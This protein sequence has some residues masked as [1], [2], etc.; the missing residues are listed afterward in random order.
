ML[1]AQQ[2]AVLP[3]F[4][5]LF[6]GARILCR[7]GTPVAKAAAQCTLAAGTI[8][9]AK[10][11]TKLA[12]SRSTRCTPVWHPSASCASGS[13]ASGLGDLR[14]MLARRTTGKDRAPLRVPPIS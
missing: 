2:P 4:A 8:N 7:Q 6:S 3:P 1:A 14:C 13:N 12:A 5:C 11:C 10:A 9:I